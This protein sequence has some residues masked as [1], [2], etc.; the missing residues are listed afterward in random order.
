MSSWVDPGSTTEDPARRRVA[1]RCGGEEPFRFLESAAASAA[2][3]ALL[4]FTRRRES[5]GDFNGSQK[6]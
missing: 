1:L 4:L 3:A 5:L 2:S 6:G